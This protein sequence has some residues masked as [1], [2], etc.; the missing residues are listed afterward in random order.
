MNVLTVG[1]LLLIAAILNFTKSFLTSLVVTSLL[2]YKFKAFILS[3]GPILEPTV[4]DVK[5]LLNL[6]PGPLA[7]LFIPP[8]FTRCSYAADPE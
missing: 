3:I 2:E 7:P 4:Y 1:F 6:L 5:S 8:I